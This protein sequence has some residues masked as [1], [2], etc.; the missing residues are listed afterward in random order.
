MTTSDGRL[1][2]AARL[3]SAS[4]VQ[5]L[6]DR[7]YAGVEAVFPDTFVGFDVLDP[8]THRPLRTTASGV[9]KFF[10]SRY[11]RFARED[12]PI[13]NE[14]IT[15][16]TVAYNLQSMTLEEWTSHHIYR[17]VFAMHHIVGLVYAPVKVGG[18]VVATLNFGRSAQHALFS[19]G[20]IEDAR[21]L[22]ELVGNVM[23]SL[24][25]VEL[26]ERRAALYGDA[27]D[28]VSEPIVITDVAGALRY[29]N[30]VA[31]RLLAQRADAGTSFDEAVVAF[32]NHSGQGAATQFV[33]WIAAAPSG[34]AF[35]AFLLEDPSDQQI[36]E[37]LLRVLTPREAAVFSLV[38]TGMRDREVAQ[39]LNLSVHTVKGY[40]REVFRKSGARSRSELARIAASAERHHD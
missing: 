21:G 4:S 36:P 14:A 3:T 38:A 39:Q 24:G 7:L 27:L 12:D 18:R 2:F 23:T 26:I 37:W 34:E 22:A 1:G 9:S 16:G 17:E 6:A 25:R 15:Q 8:D 20:E 5:D 40:L 33:R 29:P 31:Q 11:D 13:L 32:E 19:E 35:V 30:A 28:L 10:L